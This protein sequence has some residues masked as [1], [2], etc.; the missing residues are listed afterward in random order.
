MLLD[1]NKAPFLEENIQIFF[2]TIDTSFFLYSFLNMFH[3]VVFRNV[4]LPLS[5]FLVLKLC[6]VYKRI[7]GV[8]SFSYFYRG[9]I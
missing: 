2:E 4:H 9:K 1:W 3:T 8:V 6:L 7:P 5:N